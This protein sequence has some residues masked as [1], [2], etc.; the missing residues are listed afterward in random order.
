MNA[1]A[2]ACLLAQLSV[3]PARL[4]DARAEPH[5]WLTYSGTYDGTRHSPLRQIDTASVAAL[6]PAWVYQSRE[7]GKIETSPIV[8]DGTIFITEK[9]H[10]VTALD[11]RTG[12]PLWSYRRPPV[13]VAG[14]CGPVNRGAAVLG[15]ALYFGTLDAH[16]VALDLNSGKVRWDVTLADASQGYSLTAAPLAVKDKIIVGV[17][18]GEFATR[19]FLDA[20]DASTGARVWRFWTVPA[21]GQPGHETWKGDSWKTGGATTWVTGAYDP[22]LNLVYWGTGNPAPNYDGDGR[23]GDN[24]YS[25][26]LLALDPDTGQR[27]WHFQFTP[28]D[29]HDWDS[30]QVPMLIDA[31]WKGRPRKLVAQVNRNAFYY[32]LD[33][34]TG[35]FLLGA[36]YSKQTWAS[37]LDG[38]GRP[39]R[40]PNTAPSVEGTVVFPGL[41][42]GTNWYSPSYHPGTQLI[43]VQAHDNY[44]QTFFKRAN[45][46]PEP[47]KLF[48]G[49][50][51]RDIEGAE[52]HGAIKAIEP[53]T[54]K[55]RWQFPLHAPPSGGV[56]STGGDLVFSGNREGMFFA[57]DARTGRPLWRFQTGGVI[58]ANPIAFAVDGKQHVAIAA[59]QAIFVF[60]LP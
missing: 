57:L 3:P 41:A 9:P 49:G 48:M 15:D 27:R 19:G 8:V 2:L 10:I 55:I 34:Q 36:P 1:L 14:C 24:L 39:V 45:Q 32:L 47:G 23:A 33:R 51:T 25:N 59:G 6:R 56:L 43:Y 16:L 30:N 28:H 52:H 35:E 42:G 60:A 18:G 21:P 53:L 22:T 58:W 5:N 31:P 54:G 38:R 20:Y 13:T 44:S 11:G 17:A 4:R 50:T 26:C 46:T 40:L 29:L 12:R 7:A 37:G